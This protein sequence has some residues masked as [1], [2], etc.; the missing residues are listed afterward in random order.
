M[1]FFPTWNENKLFAALLAVV[2]FSLVLFL[3]AKTVASIQISQRLDQPTPIE[4]TI[5]ME[6]LGKATMTPDIAVM[7]FGI[8]S[9]NKSVSEAQKQN[10][11]EMNA[12][13]DKIKATGVL[14]TDLQTKD[15]SAYEKTEWNPVTQKSESAG[16]I[17]SQSLAV[18]IRDAQKISTIVEIAGQN[19]ATSISG[20]TFTVDDQSKYEAVARE[21]ALAD[22]KQKA[23]TIAKALGLKIDRVVS[24]SEYKE[25][26]ISPMY[27]AKEM[28]MGG[29]VL[30]SSPAIQTGTQEMKLRAT[31]T[32]LLSN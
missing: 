11:K 22:A 14:E 5:Y 24:Y 16:W 25:D 3:G 9:T 28:G 2:C 32:Y 8:S 30:S 21:M 26:A 15:Y 6:G 29:G 20:P 27:G 4:H 12:L 1:S 18:K 31:V 10:S 17:V 13:I 7:T 23:D 19:G